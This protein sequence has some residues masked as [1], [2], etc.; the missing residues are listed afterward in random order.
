MEHDQTTGLGQIGLFSELDPVALANLEKRCRFRRFAPK[1]IVLDSEDQQNFDVYFV[2][3]GSVRIVNYSLAGREI[4][5]ANI[6]QGGYFGELAALTDRPRS[7]S[8]IAVTD[9]R[10]AMLAP[11]IFRRLLLDHPEMGIDVIRQL[12]QIVQ[13]CDQRI[14]DLSTLSAVQRVHVE[15]LSLA[16]IDETTPDEWIIDPL[17]THSQI[18][19]H[20]STT[21]ETVARTM[22]ALAAAGI[23][24]RKGSALQIRDHER[25]TQLA[26]S[27]AAQMLAAR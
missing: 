12:G 8:V 9:C 27:G 3:E 4:A 19:S 18:A 13:Q 17:G 25:L 20:A 15:L 21:R 2:V 6:P 24:E 22:T 11:A 5:F 7:A 26:E 16:E 14:M 10:L 23:V 1:E